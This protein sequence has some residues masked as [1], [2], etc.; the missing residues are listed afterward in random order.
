MTTSQFFLIILIHWFADFVC[1]TDRMALN[2]S[3]RYSYLLLHASIYYII[4]HVCWVLVNTESISRL[5]VINWPAHF[6][7]DGITSR[8]TSYL[9]LKNH[10]HWFFVIIGFDQVLHYGILL[11]TL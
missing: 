5:I 6:I 2:K 4:L 9:Y 8:A 7:I 1:Q 11:L 10:R 3:T